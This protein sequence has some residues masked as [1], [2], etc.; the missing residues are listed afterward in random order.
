MIRVNLEAYSM[1]SVADMDVK[2]D[3]YHSSIQKVQVKTS[4]KTYN[5][6]ADTVN[7]YDPT[8]ANNPE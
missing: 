3:G 5:L 7:N 8:T 4:F 6:D 1:E 2:Y